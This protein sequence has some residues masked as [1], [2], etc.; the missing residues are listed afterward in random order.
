MPMR[1]E[2]SF[3]ARSRTSAGT[4]ARAATRTQEGAERKSVWAQ[5]SEVLQ[6]PDLQLVLIFSLVGLLACF[7]LMLLP[8]SADIAAGLAQL[9]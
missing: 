6:N 2:L 8:F 4:G 1:G 5:I 3:P 7:A 9:S